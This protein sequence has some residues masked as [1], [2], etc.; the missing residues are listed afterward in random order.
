MKPKVSIIANKLFIV[1]SISKL[2]IILIKNQLF[3]MKTMFTNELCC[4]SIKYTSRFGRLSRKM[5]CKIYHHFILI[6]VEVLTFGHTKQK[7]L[8]LALPVIYIFVLWLQKCE[9]I[10]I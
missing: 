9:N 10:Y 6:N 7:E 2:R 1:L 5:E 3:P 4:E 8:Q